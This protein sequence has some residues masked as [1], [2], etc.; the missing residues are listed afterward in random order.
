MNSP[1]SI[2]ALCAR[3]T[4]AVCTPT[5]VGFIATTNACT[6]PG[7]MDPTA[8]ETA[9]AAAPSPVRVALSSTSASSPALVTTNERWMP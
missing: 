9:N 8:F 3:T 5:T 6:P 1:S 2:G 7:A 4:A